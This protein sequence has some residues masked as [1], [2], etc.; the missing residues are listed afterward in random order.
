MSSYS[1]AIE[2]A[3]APGTD[4]AGGADRAS[5]HEMVSTPI[6]LPELRHG[7]WT[8]HGGTALLGDSVTESLLSDLAA[9][10]RSAAQ[11]QGY[12]VGWAE[13]RRAAAAQA[14]AEAQQVALARAAEDALRADEHK[15]A[16]EALGRAAEDVRALLDQL[17]E[18]ITAQA[19]DLAWAVTTEIVGH[20]IRANAASDTV[21]R[22]L[23]VLPDTGVA[24]VRL[25]PSILDAAAVLDLADRGVTVIRDESLGPADA[26]VEANGSVTDLRID[27]AM[28]RVREVLG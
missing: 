3:A 19:T 22:V 4:R 28:A 17:S 14:E 10:T 21:A 9:K 2:R 5:V 16:L 7:E 27:E 24:V 25:H 12:A 18:R 20:Q 15:T 8:R 23:R 6:G 11:A 1:E 26:M 13:G